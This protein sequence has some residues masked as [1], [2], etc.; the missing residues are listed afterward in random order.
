MTKQIDAALELV[1]G[2]RIQL[3]EAVLDVATRHG[4]PFFHHARHQVTKLSLAELLAV[5][6]FLKGDDQ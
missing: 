2:T 6:R 4:E 1:A 3:V 5:L